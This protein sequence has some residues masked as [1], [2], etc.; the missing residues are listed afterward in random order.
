MAGPIA[1]YS[2]VH[3]IF[4]QYIVDIDSATL[5]KRDAIRVPAKVQYACRLFH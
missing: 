5:I 2:A 1:L 3:D 4:T